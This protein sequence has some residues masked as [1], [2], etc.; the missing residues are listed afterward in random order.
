MALLGWLLLCP[1]IVP[2]HH[3]LHHEKMRKWAQ[4]NQQRG[5][6]AVD[7]NTEEKDRRSSAHS[8]D[9][10]EQHENR[11]LFGHAK[12]PDKDVPNRKG[13]FYDLTGFAVSIHPLSRA[14]LYKHFCVQKPWFSVD[15][16]AMVI[17]KI[18]STTHM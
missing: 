16:C 14:I 12:P 13:Y 6:Y 18:Y 7:R 15:A 4:Q 2:L 9:A 3:E 8:Y 1:M 5:E 17:L 10:A 11:V